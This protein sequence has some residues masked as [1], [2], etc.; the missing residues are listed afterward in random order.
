[1]QAEASRFVDLRQRHQEEEFVF[2]NTHL[3]MEVW[4]NYHDVFTNF[5]VIA[6]FQAAAANLLSD[7]SARQQAAADEVEKAKVELR[8]LQVRQEAAIARKSVAIAYFVDAG[9][10]PEASA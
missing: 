4:R 9:K 2:R 10:H 8:E 1:V 6:I 5:A 7:C 3:E